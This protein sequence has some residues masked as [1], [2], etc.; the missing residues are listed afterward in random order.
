MVIIL[1]YIN[2]SNQH[3]VVHLKLTQCYMSISQFKN[4]II[5]SQ[6]DIL[7]LLLNYNISISHNP[8]LIF[9]VPFNGIP[10]MFNLKT[11]VY[12]SLE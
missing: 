3:V 11:Y 5:E 1:Q 2:V 12:S 4:L 8:D 6:I 9:I 7:S 10:S